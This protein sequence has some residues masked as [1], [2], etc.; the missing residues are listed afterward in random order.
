MISDERLPLVLL[1]ARRVNRKFV[2]RPASVVFSLLQPLTWLVLI[3]WVIDRSGTVQFDQ[4]GSF[5]SFFLP[6]AITLTICYVAFQ[7]GIGTVLELESGFGRRLVARGVNH[8]T[9]LVGRWLSDIMK[10]VV[11]VTLIVVVGALLGA[12]FQY[13]AS[14]IALLLALTVSG[15]VVGLVVANYVALLVGDSETTFA[16]SVVLIPIGLLLSGAFVP[17]ETLPA[18]VRWASVVNPVAH[19][20]S[21]LRAAL[22]GSLL[23]PAGVALAF[24]LGGFMGLL[25]LGRMPVRGHSV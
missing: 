17:A 1:L 9:L 22:N 10:G 14:T 5:I 18:V 16:I 21:G 8:R 2:R 6:T 15:I 11:Q 7:G 23:H 4:A 20:L 24:A 3:G 25:A 12:E 19:L 13:E